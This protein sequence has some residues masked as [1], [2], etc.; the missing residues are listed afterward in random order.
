M[1]V[2]NYTPCTFQKSS[3]DD[4]HSRTGDVT[5]M[6][7]I[8]TPNKDKLL[9]APPCSTGLTKRTSSKFCKI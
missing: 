2:A 9:M 8:V 3:L 5:F 6:P 7:S 4:Q 1:D